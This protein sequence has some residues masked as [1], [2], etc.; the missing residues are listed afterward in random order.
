[1]VWVIRVEVG[2]MV[3]LVKYS[4]EG[5]EGRWNAKSKHEGGLDGI[6][7]ETSLPEAGREQWLN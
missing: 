6:S 7:H 5:D 4:V 2:V 3:G 1:M